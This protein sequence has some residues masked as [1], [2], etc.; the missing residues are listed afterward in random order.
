ML[1]EPAAALGE[2]LRVGDDTPEIGE[3]T[4]GTGEEAV[5]DGQR[6]LGADAEGRIGEQIERVRDH[7][8]GRV[9]DRNDAEIRPPALHFM[10]HLTYRAGGSVLGRGAEL[11]ARGEVRVGRLGTEV[12]DAQVLLEAARR[13]DDLAEDGTYQPLRERA[14]VGARETRDHPLLPARRV[15]A[16]VRPRLLP[17]DLEGKACA[18]VQEAQELVIDPVDLLPQ[19]GNRALAKHAALAAGCSVGLPLLQRA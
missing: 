10:K 19:R 16:R 13:R 8:L 12:G 4:V 11:L 5:A 17:R 3:R 18:A 14:R 1:G 9:L 2:R 7:A 6:D 15:H